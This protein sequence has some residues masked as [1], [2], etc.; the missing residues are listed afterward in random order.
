MVF[1]CQLNEEGAK[2]H[3]TKGAKQLKNGDLDGRVSI[4]QTG[5]KLCLAIDNAIIDDLGI[6]SC[7][8]MEFVKKGTVYPN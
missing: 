8:I 2:V 7:Q 1:K 6:Y 3:W 4:T 5:T